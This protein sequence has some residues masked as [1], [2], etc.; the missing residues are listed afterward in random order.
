MKRLGILPGL[1]VILLLGGCLPSFGTEKEEVIQENEESI[2]ET[3]MIPNIQLKDEF[4][5]TLIPFKK[6][7]S[8]GLIV[9][10]MN[11][12]YDIQEAEEGLLRLSNQHFDTKNHFFQEGQHIDKETASS[13][14]SRSS[15]DEAGLNPPIKEGMS[16]ET[17]SE[18]APNYLAHIVEQNF[19]VMTDEK[20]SVLPVFRSV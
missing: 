9:S 1:A 20:N 18:E 7:A 19:L 6:S 5:K 14:L 8:R 4:Y 17:A 16:E 10:K 12:K 3:V 2:E 11:T 13:W 15:A